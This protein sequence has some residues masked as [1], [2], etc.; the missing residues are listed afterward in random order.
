[1]PFWV[2]RAIAGTVFV[3][4]SGSLLHFA[5]D[6]AGRPI[7]LAW[8][9]AVNESVWEH[10]K[11]AFWPSLGLAMF[12]YL[13]PARRHAG[14]WA[15]EGLCLP[16]APVLI[17]AIFYAYTAL[18]GSHRLFLDILTFF[19]AVAAQQA[20]SAWLHEK[21]RPGGLVGRL[22]LAL[23]GLQVAAFLVLTYQPPQAALFTDSRNG[24]RGIEAG[25][26]PGSAMGHPD[27]G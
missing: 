17:V 7:W 20:A 6:W 25:V 27:G 13:R 11:L 19:V 24:L 23:L 1:M 16:V 4:I 26:G 15:V 10:L 2:K 3:T 9:A 12:H 14:Y 8:F 5:F 22:A 21:L 18:L